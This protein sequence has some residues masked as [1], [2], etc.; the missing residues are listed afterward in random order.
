[1]GYWVDQEMGQSQRGPEIETEATWQAH[2]MKWAKIFGI[3]DPCV[4]FFKG[5]NKSWLSTSSTS[6]VASTT[7]TNRPF[8]LAMVGGYAKVVDMLF[9]LQ[10]I[11]PPA[12]LMDQNNM[13]A[14]LV[15]NL[16]KKEDIAGQWSPLD[17]SI[18]TEL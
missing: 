9:K 15:K 12:D 14:I 18:F 10:K 8:C 13:T 3:L 16:L 17:N 7:T 4:D 1:M 5:T 2:Y 11:A 6:N